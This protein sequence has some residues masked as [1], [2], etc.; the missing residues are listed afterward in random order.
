MKTIKRATSPTSRILNFIKYP[1]LILIAF[2]GFL[3]GAQTDC[4]EMAP[5]LKIGTV[6]TETNASQL[7][8][9]SEIGGQASPRNVFVAMPKHFESK[10]IT[11]EKPYRFTHPRLDKAL[12]DESDIGGQENPRQVITD[13]DGSFT[14]MDLLQEDLNRVALRDL[15]EAFFPESEIGGNQAA[16]RPFFGVKDGIANDIGGG[17]IA[18][19]NP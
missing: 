2:C 1:V 10:V 7:S 14:R 16:P 17:Q 15:A 8:I 9:D 19:R 4:E 18:P 12:K 13:L 3:V 11:Q 6:Q 5:D